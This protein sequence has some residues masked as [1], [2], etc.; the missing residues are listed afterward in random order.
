MKSLDE[1][2][3]DI[4]AGILPPL[5]LLCKSRL[6]NIKNLELFFFSKLV[7]IKCLKAADSAS[8]C[9]CNICDRGFK[10]DN[11]DPKRFHPK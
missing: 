10:K 3:W 5:L 7:N 9:V 8:D 6:S 2:T 4:V 1:I 11:A